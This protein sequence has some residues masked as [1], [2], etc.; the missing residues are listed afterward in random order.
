[1]AQSK[2]VGKGGAGVTPEELRD[3]RTSGEGEP[4]S[5]ERTRMLKR[6]IRARKRISSV[7]LTDG[8]Y[9]L[10]FSSSGLGF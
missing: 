8:L 6:L 2:A 9:M 7:G 10:G 5:E 1:M 3:G 4:V